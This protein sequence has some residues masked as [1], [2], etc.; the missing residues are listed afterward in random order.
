LDSFKAIYPSDASVQDLLA[1]EQ[2]N[3][4]TTALVLS[5]LLLQPV[6]QGTLPLEVQ[7]YT[8]DTGHSIV[9]F[10]IR[11]AFS[12]VKGRFTQWRG[13]ILYDSLRPIN[14]SITAVFETK[15]IDTGWPNRDRHLRTSDFFDVERFPTISFHSE[16]VRAMNGQWVAEGPLTMHGVTRQV[17]LPF[18]VLPGSPA[19]SQESRNLVLNLEGRLRLARTDFGILGGATFNSWFT[20]ARSATMGDSV[21]VSFEVEAWRADAE[22]FKPPVVD[23]ALARILAT[24]VGAH[25]ARLR[26]LR[27]RTGVVD[28][29]RSFR[30]QD[31][32]TRAMIWSGRPRDAA[33]LAAGL[34]ELFPELPDAHLVRGF[35]SAAA[36]DSRASADAYRRAKEA[37]V[38]IPRPAPDSLF[39]Q[40]DANWYY[41]DQLIRTGLE[42]EYA[43]AALGLARVVAELYP[44]IGRAHARLGQ[45]LALAGRTEEAR[46]SFGR[47]L[48]VDPLDT[49]APEYQ[50]RMRGK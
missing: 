38:R 19:R 27:Q 5:G 3:M 35:A 8:V 17:A 45:A 16:R 22:S 18:S 37:F 47:A 15:S 33:R 23:S 1:P 28:W 44:D 32:L 24:D 30:G 14:S 2:P 11:F 42:K 7:E 4:L 21:D 40:D 36:G 12:R 34:G 29:A 43:A 46:A 41:L 6:L 31:F 10:S 48:E 39:A 50:R 9:E 20:R 13:T 25:L 49:R 26:E